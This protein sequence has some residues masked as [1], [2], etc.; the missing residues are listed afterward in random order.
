MSNAAVQTS[1]R[2]FIKG[3]TLV[4]AGALGASLSATTDAHADE[5]VHDEAA[6]PI[7]ETYDCDIVVCG[8]GT[9]GLC[10]AWRSAELGAKVVLVETHDESGLG[11]NSRY[12]EGMSSGGCSYADG[13]LT[14]NEGPDIFDYGFSVIAGYC[15]CAC[16][17]RLLRKFVAWMNPILDWTHNVQGIDFLGLDIPL[18]DTMM[19]PPISYKP[20]D[21]ESINGGRQAIYTMYEGCKNMGVEFHFDSRAIELVV[22]EDG[23]MGGVICQHLDG[24]RMQVNAK[25]VMFATGGFSANEDMIEKYTHFRYDS[26]IPYG[27]SGSQVGDAITM[28]LSVGAALH[29]PEAL[30]FCSPVLPGHFNKSALVICGCNQAD[31]CFF[32]D[33]GERFCNEECIADWAE[34]GNTGALQKHIFT[35]I[36]QDFVE[37]IQ[38]QGPVTKRTNYFVANE[39]VPYFQEEID[40]A[41]QRENPRVVKADT[42]EELAEMLGIDGGSLVANI[43]EWNG[44][45]DEGKDHDFLKSPENMRKIQTPPF[46]GF[47]TVLA[48]YTTVGGLKCDEFSHGCSTRTTTRFPGCTHWAPT[49]RGSSE[50]CTMWPPVPVRLRCGVARRATGPARTPSRSTSPRAASQRQ[51]RRRAKATAGPRSSTM[52]SGARRAAPRP[53][54]ATLSD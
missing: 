20:S 47:K 32:N 26:L 34:S 25:A 18:N 29:H 13:V 5:A 36:D 6:T 43:E 31:T 37:K 40:E 22:N 11:G 23:S 53:P 2:S 15:H 21:D 28:G 30:Q 45:V 16:D 46:Y 44:W 41:L 10:G 49:A 27:T 3:A 8:S 51:S 12:V 4:G 50:A 39:P 17:L 35:I 24:S 42:L 1:R 54:R 7:T 14:L 48:F 9:A 52:R 19:A 33:K 38:T